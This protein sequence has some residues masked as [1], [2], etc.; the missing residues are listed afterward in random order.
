MDEDIEIKISREQLYN[1]IWTLS[2]VGVA[3]KYSVPYGP[4]L[5]LCKDFSIP[6]PPSG[7][8]IKLSYGKPVEKMP[9]PSFTEEQII[10][11][12]IQLKK[13]TKQK[14]GRKKKLSPTQAN[15]DTAVKSNISPE[16][17]IT[18]VS[19]MQDTDTASSSIQVVTTVQEPVDE[20]PKTYTQWGQTY[21]IYNRETLYKEVWEKP[22]TEVAKKYS[23]S[24]VA[25]H[26]VCKSL[27][28][29]TPPNGYWAKVYAGKPVV[30]TPLPHSD[31]PIQKH[32][33]RSGTEN[34]PQIEGEPLVFL[35]NE[36]RIMILAVASQIQLPD[37]NAK[38]Y[39]KII[40]HRRTITEWSKSKNNY[41]NQTVPY[42]ADT[43][44]EEAHPRVLRVFDALIRAMEP[45]GCSLTDDLKF[46]VLNETVSLQVSEAKDQVNHVNTKEENMQLLKYE[47]EKRHSSYAYKPII[48]KYDYIYNGRISV[49]VQNSKNFRDC[50]SYV[51]ED[52]L[53]DILIQIY[54]TS[55]ILRKDREAREEA[56]RKRQEEARLREER[57][58][59]YNEEIDRVKALTNEAEDYDI[60]CK[61]RKYVAAVEATKE[62]DEKT[63]VWIEWAKAKADWFDPTISKKDAQMGKREHEKD[64][65]QKKL[66]HARYG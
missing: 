3:K 56:E 22:V 13:V 12:I 59:Q 36:E 41:R 46:I 58:I 50:K 55:N 45:L 61:I 11:S 17:K 31:K 6:I 53:G 28:V 62:L 32:G 7:Y 16:S 20:S 9:L 19:D 37:E 29:P 39:S 47:D 34:K 42:L 66:E 35:D 15:I 49:T 63:Q 4:L 26:K 48:R 10:L 43:V 51:V 52:R 60:A 27:D 44:S 30:K 8:W 21:N 65:E 38:M 57:R 25:I 18:M 1:E 5:K 24:D 64:S 40:A 54:E 14:T 23:V 33:M 2:V